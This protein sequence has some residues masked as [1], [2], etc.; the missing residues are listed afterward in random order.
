MN[1]CSDAKPQ[2]WGKF[3]LYTLVINNDMPRMFQ[4]ENASNLCDVESRAQV[5]KFY[6]LLVLLNFDN[7]YKISRQDKQM[8][9]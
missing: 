6:L 1:E 4:E 5:R 8:N 3:K 9:F 2:Q 7:S